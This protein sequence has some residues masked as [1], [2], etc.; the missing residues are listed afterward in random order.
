ML[1]KQNQQMLALQTIPGIGPFTATVLVSSA[2]DINTFNTRLQL[3]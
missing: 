1:D 3:L 2:T